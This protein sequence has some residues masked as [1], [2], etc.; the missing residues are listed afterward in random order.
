MQKIHAKTKVLLRLPPLEAALLAYLG[1]LTGRKNSWVLRDGLRALAHRLPTFDPDAFR[2]FVAKERLPDL[3][4]K[5]AGVK[6]EE[7]LRMFL[8]G[9]SFEAQMVQDDDV[10][11][12]GSKDF[13]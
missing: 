13:A 6:L 4:G 11:F 1:E 7:D 10:E 3:D 9:E 8:E 12:D 5:A 2:R